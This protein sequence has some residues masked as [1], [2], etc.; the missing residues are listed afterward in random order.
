MKRFFALAA[1][2]AAAILAGS[3]C[4][5]ISDLFAPSYNPNS[6]SW[7]P[8]VPVELAARTGSA[9]SRPLRPDDV[10]KVMVYT[11]VSAQPSVTEDV[12]DADGTITLPFVGDLVVGGRTVS[13]AGKVVRNAYMESGIYQ[14]LEVT[15]I[16]P[17]MIQQ[18]M[19]T[20]TG[21]VH[22]RGSMQ[23]RDGLGLKEAI[24]DAGDLTDFANGTVTVTRNGRMQS[25][26]LTRIKKG[27]AENPLLLPDDYVEAMESRF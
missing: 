21:A 22:K 26:N 16:C 11:P 9:T 1:V 25:Y 12:V 24:A 10:V 7:V 6:S 20:V 3:G 14:S 13:E 15:V 18:P 8:P 23:W 5:A 19:L 2:C 17:N 27:K 4:T